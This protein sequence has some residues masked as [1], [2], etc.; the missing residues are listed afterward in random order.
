MF[1]ATQLGC[2]RLGIE[3]ISTACL[4]CFLLSTCCLLRMRLIR[5]LDDPIHVK[6][7]KL[8][9]K[10]KSWEQEICIYYSSAIMEVIFIIIQSLN[11]NNQSD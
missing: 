8:E 1:G 4:N 7:E 11:I 9:K 5:L 3:W 10:A 2:G 6:S